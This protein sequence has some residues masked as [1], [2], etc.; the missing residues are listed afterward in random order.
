MRSRAFRDSGYP[1][2][3]QVGIDDHIAAIRELA[4]HHPEMSLSQV[5]VQGWSWGGTFAAQAIL[6]RPRFYKVAVSGA[7]VYD[8]AA[9]YEAM[10]PMI[11]VPRYANGTVYRS[12]PADA[13][14][15]WRKLEVVGM[16]DRLT[17][18]LL[19]ITGDLDENVPS[20]QAYRLIDALTRANKPY[21]LIYLPNRNH[22]SGGADPYTIER[23][24]DYFVQ[25]LRGVSPVW[26]YKIHI[27]AAAPVL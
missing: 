25:Y 9:L 12:S 16:A 18:H 21:D 23:T 8:Y 20:V 26:D 4:H 14:V 11:G 24:W 6:S 7:G 1:G 22:L 13:P 19:L 3:T 2:F 10:D 27:G 17:G 15:N 5:G